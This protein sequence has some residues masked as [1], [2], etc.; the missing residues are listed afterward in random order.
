MSPYFDG[1]AFDPT[2]FD[3][4][5]CSTGGRGGGR[6]VQLIRRPDLPDPLLDEDLLL[7][8]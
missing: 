4:S 1:C 5:V 8:T 7:V 6:R 2:Y 3:A